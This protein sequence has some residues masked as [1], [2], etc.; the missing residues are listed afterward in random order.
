MQTGL[1]K[2][3]FYFYDTGVE[4]SFTRITEFKKEMEKETERLKGLGRG[5]TSFGVVYGRVTFGKFV[6]RMIADP[7]VPTDNVDWSGLAKAFAG[8]NRDEQLQKLRA[9]DEA[10]TQ[11]AIGT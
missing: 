10:L 11:Q 7:A 6:E 5:P 3:S 2:E 4:G 9:V 8:Y 1:K